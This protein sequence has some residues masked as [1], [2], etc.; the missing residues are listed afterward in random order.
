VTDREERSR[1]FF[2]VTNPMK[3]G[4]AL[5]R[6]AG[7]SSD[8]SKVLQVLRP[9]RLRTDS[10]GVRHCFGGVGRT[11]GGIPSPASRKRAPGGPR[12]IAS[13]EGIGATR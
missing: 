10:E 12:R 11:R 6:A 7:R 5:W 13:Q 8:L 1:A 9:L 3:V 4:D 2:D